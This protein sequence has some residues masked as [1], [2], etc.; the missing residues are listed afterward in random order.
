M[1]IT[2]SQPVDGSNTKDSPLA[3]A[4]VAEITQCALALAFL[5]CCV[6]F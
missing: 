6:A 2:I 4:A 3:V 5:K 1:G